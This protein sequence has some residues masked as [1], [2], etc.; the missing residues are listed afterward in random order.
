MCTVPFRGFL[1]V[2]A[3]VWLW[4]GQGN[5]GMFLEEGY[6]P[7]GEYIPGWEYGPG[8][9]YSPTLLVGCNDYCLQI[10]HLTKTIIVHRKYLLIV[11]NIIIWK[12]A[13]Q[14]WLLPLY[15]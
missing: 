14:Y 9:G 5:R 4:R 7:G 8:R 12:K 6:G 2:E 10:N 13:S 15:H 1:Y 11:M 3:I